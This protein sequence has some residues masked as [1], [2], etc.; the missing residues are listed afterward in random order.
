MKD[1][2]ISVEYLEKIESNVTPDEDTGK[3]IAMANYQAKNMV[4]GFVGKKL[5]LKP[6]KNSPAE[7]WIAL[8]GKGKL[9]EPRE[10]L[11]NICDKIDVIFNEFNGTGIMMCSN[12]LERV[13]KLVKIEYPT[14]PIAV[15]KLYCKVRFFARLRKLNSNV[16]MRSMFVNKSVRA[17]KQLSQFVN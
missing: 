1:E 5:G 8:K 3:F 10:G 9:F 7:S 15:V 13:I 11:K 16:K 12:P 17:S 4:V 2:F 6:K 14:F